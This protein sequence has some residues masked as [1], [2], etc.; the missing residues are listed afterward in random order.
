MSENQHTEWKESWRD[1]YLRWI[2]GFAN[3]EG[4]VLVIGRDDQ[5]RV[6]G[7][8]DAAGSVKRTRPVAGIQFLAHI[9]SGRECDGW[10]KVSD[11]KGYGH[12]GE[13]FGKNFDENFG[14]NCR[15]P[16]RSVTQK[17]AND[18]GRS[19]YRSGTKRSSRRN[20]QC[21]AGQGRQSAIRWTT[22]GR[23][24]GGF[25]MSNCTI[26]NRVI[27]LFADPVRANNLGAAGK[28][29]VRGDE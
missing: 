22:K 10:R 16:A 7:L 5:G 24:L 4:G 19:C 2:S 25:S 28:I 3:A 9:P 29:D 23:P 8:A 17:P 18:P 11:K 1:E 13:N 12:F 20:G 6:V 15:C 14:E 21:Q 27:T 26:R